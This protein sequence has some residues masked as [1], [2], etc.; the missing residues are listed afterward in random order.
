MGDT[1][2]NTH[3]GDTKHTLGALEMLKNSPRTLFLCPGTPDLGH[4]F[5]AGARLC[6]E[7]FEVKVRGSYFFVY[8]QE[9]QAH[10][11]PLCSCSVV[12]RD[13]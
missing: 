3:G 12:L 13:N 11:Q 4:P 10:K 5:P 2:A 6:Q 7:W 8:T 9:K 1:G